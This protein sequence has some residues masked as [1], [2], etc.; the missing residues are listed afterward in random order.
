[1]IC[2]EPSQV[3][4]AVARRCG[5]L[6]HP[7]AN[8][9]RH[10]LIRIPATGES[11]GLRVFVGPQGI[12]MFF[13]H[14]KIENWSLKLVDFR[15]VLI[16]GFFMNWCRPW[17][18]NKLDHQVVGWIHRVFWLKI[19]DCSVVLL[20]VVICCNWNCWKWFPCW[21]SQ[22]AGPAETKDFYLDAFDGGK[23]MLG[24][25]RCGTKKRLNWVI[26]CNLRVICL[27]AFLDIPS[28]IYI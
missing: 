17:W 20:F 22:R 18:I 23:L 25:F 8:V 15:V 1:M 27:H 13:N 6:C 12:W 16:D 19:V 7:L 10:V 5:L 28:I 9:P 24:L 26:P 11:T 4:A 3:W 14:P 2:F 21:T